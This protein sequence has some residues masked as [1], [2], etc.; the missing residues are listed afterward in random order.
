MIKGITNKETI[1]AFGSLG[2]VADRLSTAATPLQQISNL[3]PTTVRNFF[4][5]AIKG[6]NKLNTML[7]TPSPSIETPKPKA[8][9]GPV[10]AGDISLVGEQG[11][12]LVQF[13][14]N[15]YVTPTNQTKSALGGTSIDYGKMATAIAA[16]LH[17]A[18][19]YTTIKTDT[20]YAGS[21]MNSKP[22]L[23]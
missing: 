3:L 19:I 1:N 10:S 6:M 21:S 7:P 8:A 11:P 23:G 22:N 18:P 16:A 9:G 17:A 12:E 20:L 15:A 2:I 14:R 13:S 5:T 4:D